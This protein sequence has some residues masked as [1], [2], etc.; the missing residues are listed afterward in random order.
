MMFFTQQVREAVNKFKAK[1]TNMAVTDVFGAEGLERTG[2]VTLKVLMDF[3]EGRGL[4]KDNERRSG[5]AGGNGKKNDS[6]R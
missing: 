3:A 5:D 2:E 4:N 6:Q 1:L